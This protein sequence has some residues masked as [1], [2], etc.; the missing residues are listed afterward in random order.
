M[1]F[2]GFKKI[3]KEKF[4]N[5]FPDIRRDYTGNGIDTA[6]SLHIISILIFWITP[7]ITIS[8]LVKIGILSINL[9]D[10]LKLFSVAYTTAGTVWIA[11]GVRYTKPSQLNDIELQK[12]V[13]FTFASASRHCT[14][15]IF[16]FLLGIAIQLA[17]ESQYV[18]SINSDTNNEP[19]YE[20]TISVKSGIEIKPNEIYY[21]TVKIKNKS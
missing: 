20:C 6:N 16:I 3:S 2:F 14:I 11:A 15:G 7:I 8:S 17:A 10:L 19:T 21:C 9:E 12:H 4:K 18:K 5:L 13:T 1:L